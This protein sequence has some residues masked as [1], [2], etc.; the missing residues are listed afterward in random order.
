LELV[1]SVQ[2]VLQLGQAEMQYQSDVAVGS[3]GLE[4]ELV[5][6]LELQQDW[7]AP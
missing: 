6:A 3:K 2:L 1:P 4:L 7:L 5:L